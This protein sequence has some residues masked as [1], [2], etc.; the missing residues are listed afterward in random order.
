M[1]RE[2]AVL[3]EKY[4]NLETQQ[5]DLIKTYESELIKLRETNDQLTRNLT[6]DKESIHGE[7]EKWR[8]LYLETERQNQD[9]S[10]NYDKDK[11]LWD[12]KFKFLEQQKDQ[13]KKDFEEASR[14]FQMTVESLQKNQNESKNKTE[15][16]HSTILAQLE[17]KYQQRIKEIQENQSFMLNELQ[18]KTKQLER[19]NRQLMDKI[20]I[21]NKSKQNEQGG[22][23]KK[24]EKVM[25]ERDRLADEVDQVKAERDNK[26]IE[27]QKMLEKDRESYK[28]RLRETEGKGTNVQARQTEMLLNFEKE[29]A[30]F[31]HEKSYLISQKEDAV[32]NAQ[33]FEK[34]VEQLLRDNEKL[35]N[36]LKNSRKNMY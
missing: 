30:K 15:I 35:K 21:T 32:E 28:Q 23:E 9:I 4:Q 31:E 7:V 11:A 27:Y 22:L 34:K 5:K 19:E 24:L 14:K 25:E 2:K 29:R 1:D 20:E 10:N 13:A 26:I 8:N 33:R 17:S 16:A 12:G 18:T 3:V 6:L 36:D